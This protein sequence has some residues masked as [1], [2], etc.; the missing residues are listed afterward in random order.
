MCQAIIIV[1]Y[2]NAH[3]R[4]QRRQ[5]FIL[6]AGMVVSLGHSHRLSSAGPAL[7]ARVNSVSRG[8]SSFTAGG[9]HPN[10]PNSFTLVIRDGREY[11]RHSCETES[12]RCVPAAADQLLERPPT[13][14]TVCDSKLGGVVVLGNEALPLSPSSY[15]FTQDGLMASNSAAQQ[16]EAPLPTLSAAVAGT[17]TDDLAA[18]W[19]VVPSYSFGKANYSSE[20][21]DRNSSTRQVPT[22]SRSGLHV[23]RLLYA[24]YQVE[25][26]QHLRKEFGQQP[27]DIAAEDEQHQ[28]KRTRLPTGSNSNSI[29]VGSSRSKLQQFA[30]KL[31][32]M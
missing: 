21:L 27:G 6:A 3:T 26:L 15:S 32:S 13:L 30:S 8:G 2:Q 5:V 12:N 25:Q 4:P 1:N 19:D 7:A 16:H 10:G 28:R 14:H 24:N 9:I 29:A 23:A 31:Q 18:A 17:A 20:P 22:D 11:L